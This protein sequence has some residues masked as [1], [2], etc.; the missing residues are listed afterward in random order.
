VH[1]HQPS[2]TDVNVKQVQI[3]T[4][5]DEEKKIFTGKEIFC[6]LVPV[7]AAKHREHPV[8]AKIAFSRQRMDSDK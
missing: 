5:T 7:E 1:S 6:K 4:T 3:S 2:V 8:C